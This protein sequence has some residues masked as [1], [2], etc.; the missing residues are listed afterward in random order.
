MDKWTSELRESP[1][2]ST[3]VVFARLNRSHLPNHVLGGKGGRCIN[4]NQRPVGAIVAACGCESARTPQEVSLMWQL[5][6]IIKIIL[7]SYLDPL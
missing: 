1:M 4:Y 5:N 7:N 3:V 2:V 6:K